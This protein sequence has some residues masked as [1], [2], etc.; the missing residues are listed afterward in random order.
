MHSN[1]IGSRATALIQFILFLVW[2]STKCAL[3]VSGSLLSDVQLALSDVY[4]WPYSYGTFATGGGD[5]TVS[6]WDPAAKKRLRQFPTYPSPISALDFN[7]D[8]SKLA[9]AFSETDNTGEVKAK[10][11]GNGIWIRECGEEVKPK[12]K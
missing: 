4:H 5:A 8:G 10:M 12:T 6:L 7:A 9:I 11:G 1:V 2:L 3:V